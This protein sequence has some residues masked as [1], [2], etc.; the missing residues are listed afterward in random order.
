MHSRGSAAR[1]GC[2]WPNFW[3]DFLTLGGTAIL[4]F[5]TCTAASAAA[6]AAACAS[7]SPSRAASAAA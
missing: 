3:A 5:L 2:S 4:H 6:W 1:K 7:A